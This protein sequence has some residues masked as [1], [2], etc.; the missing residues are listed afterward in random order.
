LT[1]GRR[2][3]GALERALPRALAAEPHRGYRRR[4]VVARS[5]GRR[6]ALRA[7]MRGRG[8]GK[9]RSTKPSRRRRRP[10][11]R[12]RGSRRRREGRARTRT[13]GHVPTRRISAGAISES[14]AGD[15]IADVVAASPLP[16]V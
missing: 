6:R 10:R 9:E 15:A 2:A 7:L 8:E 1:R 11:N 16:R 14:R 12:R 4:E 3:R 13:I 5:R